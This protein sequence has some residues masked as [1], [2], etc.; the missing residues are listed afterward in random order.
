MSHTQ[1]AKEH[2]ESTAELSILNIERTNP[3]R[4]ERF[5]AVASGWEVVYSEGMV[6]GH[7]IM[8]DFDELEG[9]RRTQG[10]DEA[11]GVKRCHYEPQVD[12]LHGAQER[13]CA[14]GARQPDFHPGAG[15]SRV[16]VDPDGRR[17]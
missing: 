2:G 12:D 14:I 10:P 16:L 5:Y 6:E 8:I 1:S 7:S 11:G 4:L 9:F 17:Y 3:A 13:T 15:L